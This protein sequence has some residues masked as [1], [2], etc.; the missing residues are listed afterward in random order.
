MSNFGKH[1]GN[2]KKSGNSGDRSVWQVCEKTGHIAN[3]CFILRDLLTSKKV[4]HLLIIA[5]AFTNEPVSLDSSSYT[6]MLDTGASQHMISKSSQVPNA[7]F[8]LGHDEV[9]LRNGA[10]LPISGVG[11]ESFTDHNH[12]CILSLTDLFHTLYA[13]ANLLS[14]HK[15]CSDNNVSIEFYSSFFLVKDLDTRKVVIQS[16]KRVYRVH[17]TVHVSNM[18]SCVQNK[19]QS[20]LIAFKESLETWLK[21]KDM[22]FCNC[23]ANS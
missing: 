2:Y 23:S 14:A 7:W 10:R 9:L 19:G 22:L 11:S 4:Q 3:N 21:Q 16:D 6:W 8:Y 5:Q 13:T 18:C 17:S 20:I 15:F 1:S 12:Q